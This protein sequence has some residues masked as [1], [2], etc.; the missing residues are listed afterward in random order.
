MTPAP[1]PPRLKRLARFCLAGIALASLPQ[2]SAAAAVPDPLERGPYAVTEVQQYKAGKVNLQEP[3]YLGTA[4][5]GATSAANLQVRGSLYYPTNLGRPAR[6]ILLVH[7]NHGSCQIANN[8]VTPAVPGGG[9][10]PNCSIFNR[11]DL[12]YGYL[13]SNLASHGYAVASID[14]DQLMYYQDTSAKG[15]HQRRLMIAAQ[16]DAFWEANTTAIPDDADHNLGGSLVGKLDMSHIGLMGHS[17]GGDAVTS[18]MDYNRER[19]APGRRYNLDGVISLAPVDY[20]RRAPYGS[21]YLTILP[22]CD[23]D[24][25]NL[26]GARFFERSQYV[27]PGDPFPKIQMYLL[28]ANHNFF[29]TVW[30]A[31][32]D[33]AS[34]ADA[35][36]G[37][38]EASQSTSIRLS[39]G[40]TVGA[41]TSPS[42]ILTSGPNAGDPNPARNLLPV[43][44]RTNAFSSDQALMGDQQKIGLATMNAFFR[45]YVGGETQFDPYMTG[46][47][48]AQSGNNNLPA[49]ACPTSTTGTRIACDQYLQT[50]YF[51][52]AAE[53]TDVIGPGTDNATTVSAVG[54][55]IQASG[56]S[57]PYT[58]DGGVTPKPATTE[59]GI[60]WCNPEPDHFQPS[61]VG[62]TL[63]PTA[64]KPC[65]LP[66]TNVPG[67][68]SSNRE[69]GPVNQS[70]GNQLALA[71]DEPATLSTRI[72]VADGDLRA[73]KSL[74]LGAA[75]NY[76]DTRNGVRTAEQAWNPASWKTDF[77]ITLTDASGKTA[78]VRAGDRRYGTALQQTTGSANARLHIVLNQIRVPLTDFA[79]IDLG[80]IRKLTL[81]FGGDGYPASGSI[82]LADVRFQESIN[83][84]TALTG[85]AGSAEP[86]SVIAET[87]RLAASAAT[88]DVLELGASAQAGATCLDTV[89]PTAKVASKKLARRTLTIKGTAADTGCGA[90]VKSV[91]VSIG[92]KV[93]GKVRYVTGS[94]TLSK[95]LLKSTPIA[96]VAKGK[97]TWSLTASKLAKGSYAIT[98][99]VI[100]AGGNTTTKSAGT[101]TVR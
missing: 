96:L 3:N 99:T 54:T 36:C 29:N 26:Q 25:S 28:G 101:V 41:L 60:D 95:P 71:W 81:A 7:G 86:A 8:N 62:S 98:V 88:P 2:A 9:S 100:D 52:P 50:D 4:P 85:R 61:Y 83:G 69:Q 92:K 75:V 37:P 15:M 35:A 97:G 44:T 33:D 51:A 49:S 66:A 55:A 31:D 27:K 57:N 91:Q 82:Q 12:G 53:R 18:F 6:F 87:P 79:G 30:S 65:P 24:V 23:G 89:K 17:R 10:A 90:A 76:F 56:F 19:P 72:P 63:Q 39:G 16:L 67:G 93:G 84:P 47:L 42:N 38:V 58:D 74:T 40:Q 48:T 20:E 13:A 80:A 68:Q 94:G 78:T 46:E 34:S 14:Q 43:Y 77:A 32:S 1:I 45:R 59:S 70:Y 22:A 73:K 21:A 11:N 64:A 5:S